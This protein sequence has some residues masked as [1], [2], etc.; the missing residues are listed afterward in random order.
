MLCESLKRPRSLRERSVTSAELQCEPSEAALD[1]VTGTCVMRA[2][3]LLGN[4]EGV[5]RVLAALEG[6][7]NDPTLSPWPWTGAC[8]TIQPDTQ[9]YN[10][11]MAAAE[12]VSGAR[13]LLSDLELFERTA[14][15]GTAVAK[16][17]PVKDVVTYNTLISALT[18]ARRGRAALAL[19][20][21]MKRYG[22]QPNKITYATLMRH[23]GCT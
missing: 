19:F 13:E 2:Q 18:R 12:K 23:V 3:S 4:G 15:P 7:S 14:D 1:I 21:E 17:K 8:G 6:R 16:G 22:L 11:A 10:V 20:N 5:L 9:C